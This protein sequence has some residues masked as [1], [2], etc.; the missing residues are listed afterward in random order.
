MCALCSLQIVEHLERTVDALYVLEAAFLDDEAF[1]YQVVVSI[2]VEHQR[3]FFL[4]VAQGYSY[5]ACS[6]STVVEDAVRASCRDSQCVGDCHRFALGVVEGN[7][8]LH[9]VV[10][11]TVHLVTSYNAQYAGGKEYDMF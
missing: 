2:D 9:N 4:E 8:A 10:E 1:L 7:L 3:V 6:H 11:R 5:A